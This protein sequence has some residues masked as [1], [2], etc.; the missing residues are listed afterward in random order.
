LSFQGGA[1]PFPLV[2]DHY[3]IKNATGTG[4][5][6]KF[7]SVKEGGASFIVGAK[8]AGIPAPDPANIDWVQ[9]ANIQGMLR[10]STLVGFRS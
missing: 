9:L 8:A 6:P 5:S 7:A 10:L 2:V 4:I 1:T 3:F